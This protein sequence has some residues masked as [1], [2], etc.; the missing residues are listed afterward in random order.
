[1][2]RKWSGIACHLSC[3]LAQEYFVDDN[4]QEQIEP[5][6]SIAMHLLLFSSLSVLWVLMSVQQHRKGQAGQM[7]SHLAPALYNVLSQ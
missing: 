1:M 6:R 5:H 2:V 3:S 7:L 4:I